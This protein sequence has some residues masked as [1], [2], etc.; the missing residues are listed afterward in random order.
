MVI[1]TITFAIG[2]SVPDDG[3]PSLRDYLRN[4]NGVSRHRSSAVL[5]RQIFAQD[6]NRQSEEGKS[7]WV[8]GSASLV[9]DQI[10]EAEKNRAPWGSRCTPQRD[11]LLT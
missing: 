7:C 4:G 11:F 3:N 6:V 8:A 10:F 1:P 5:A 2:S 9:K